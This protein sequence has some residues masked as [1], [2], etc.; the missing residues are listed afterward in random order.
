M[1]DEKIPLLHEDL[2][3]INYEAKN[4]NDLLTGLSKILIDKGYVKESYTSGILNREKN[5]PTGLNTE[6][7]KVAIPHTDAKYVNVPAILIAKLKNP[8]IFKEMSSGTEDVQ[9][10]L[11]FMLAIKDPN[12]QLKTLSKIMEIF[13]DGETLKSI[14]ESDSASKIIKK[15]KPIIGE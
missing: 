7:V 3:L 4:R 8:V 2:V 10:L 6:G 9:V 11:V 13:S 12:I 1:M 15:L 14:Y 5:F